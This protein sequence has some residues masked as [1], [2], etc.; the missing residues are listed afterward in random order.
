MASSRTITTHFKQF[1]L[2]VLVNLVGAILTFVSVYHTTTTNQ[3]SAQILLGSNAPTYSYTD[4]GYTQPQHVRTISIIHVT[5]ALNCDAFPDHP[6]Y[7][8]YAQ[9]YTFLSWFNAQSFAMYQNTDNVHPILKVHHYRNI[10][11]I[12]NITLT[13]AHYPKDDAIIPNFITI[14]PHLNRSLKNSRYSQLPNAPELKE[15]Y[16]QNN[17]LKDIPFIH[18]IIQAAYNHQSTSEYIIYSN[19]DIGVHKHF[20][21]KVA[22]FILN[23]HHAFQINRRGISKKKLF[24]RISS[25]EHSTHVLDT[26]SKHQVL[27]AV[28]SE[29]YN[30]DASSKHGGSDCFVFRRR[31]WK[32]M[33]LGD[34]F[35]GYGP[36]G[37][38]LRR[39]LKK[40]FGRQYH[41]YKCKV[42]LT[43]HIGIQRTG[44]KL[45]HPVTL[46]NMRLWRE[47]YNMTTPDYE[48]EFDLN[49]TKLFIGTHH[50][51][52]TVLL[53][54]RIIPRIVNYWDTQCNG[55][56]AM[57]NW[58][59]ALHW[60]V[61]DTHCTEQAI[62]AFV[63]KHTRDSI[64]LHVIRDPVDTVFS[65]YNYHKT[66]D[67]EAWL[68]QDI[69]KV[70]R[71]KNICELMMQRM[72]D[73]LLSR[74]LQ[75]IYQT[76]NLSIGLQIEYYRYMLCE[77]GQI[78]NSYHAILT[79]KHNL[80][81]GNDVRFENIRL[82][83]FEDNF[84]STMQM[85]LDMVGIHSVKHTNN[86]MNA[87]NVFNIYDKSDKKRIKQLRHVTVGRY[88]KTQQINVLL[89]DNNRCNALKRATISLDYA[90]KYDMYC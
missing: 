31:G 8:Y 15:Y 83:Q 59:T 12:L 39:E 78:N 38:A 3:I 22:H 5:N 44:G 74:S 81:Y 43:F 48:C 85:I 41:T 42:N 49:K 62:D 57:G 89:S 86:I 19:A 2:I 71:A 56:T 34:V 72:D 88:N 82:E 24:E 17:T 37:F 11:F 84:N 75:N 61:K 47:R 14:L 70:K 20:Y 68:K 4:H 64:I 80:Q 90:W 26:T 21:L 35:I 29:M 73:A 30:G 55:N 13:S 58:L 77:L 45:K 65:G 51:T 66:T 1:L 23:G 36:I 87:V 53:T 79:H 60:F 16:A 63:R 9:P 33:V 27:D 10:T 7:L 46:L 25:F 67:K 6:S 40:V 54:R 32:D 69:D 50:K 52:G 76:M 28:Y 18:D